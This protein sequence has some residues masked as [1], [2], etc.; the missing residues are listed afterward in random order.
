MSRPARWRRPR[1]LRLSAFYPTDPLVPYPL[2]PWPTAFLIAFALMLLA[3]TFI[4]ARTHAFETALLLVI[5]A[6]FFTVYADRSARRTWLAMLKVRERAI[7]T[8][9]YAATWQRVP[10][11]AFAGDVAMLLRAHGY[12]VGLTERVEGGEGERPQIR[13]RTPD[14]DLLVVFC[15]PEEDVGA[16]RLQALLGAAIVG[17]AQRMIVA[18]TGRVSLEA[19]RTA[20]DLPEHLLDAEIWD[21]RVLAE[22]VVEVAHQHTQPGVLPWLEE[23]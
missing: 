12:V 16:Q 9:H 4:E 5:G 6:G 23:G 2:S 21:A 3:V 22:K 18:T 11:E 17:R 8:L 7:G 20:E 10:R 15:L 19:Q 1:R 13:G 14:G